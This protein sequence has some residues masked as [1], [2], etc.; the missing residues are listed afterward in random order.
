MV[1]KKNGFTL[2]EVLV[3]VII[4]I[5]LAAFVMI[6]LK[7]YRQDKSLVLVTQELANEIA[8]LRTKT[9][10]GGGFVDSGG[11]TVFPDNYR[12]E[13]A[14]HGYSLVAIIK[15]DQGIEQEVLLK[16]K[17]WNNYNFS[18]SPSDCQVDF[19]LLNDY[20]SCP[21]DQID[22]VIFEITNLYGASRQIS[23]DFISGQ[24]SY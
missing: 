8:E 13:I 15:D 11:E 2:I 19:D 14:S 5:S 6:N 21:D 16:D 22:K 1:L 18:I 7:N 9:V 10:A 20:I 23:F 3:S 17:S 12:L 4:I 24:L